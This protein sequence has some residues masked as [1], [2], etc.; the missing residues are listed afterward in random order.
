MEIAFEILNFVK[1][2]IFYVSKNSEKNT[3]V[4]EGITH[5]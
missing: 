5:M 1:F 4:H 2:H 3:D